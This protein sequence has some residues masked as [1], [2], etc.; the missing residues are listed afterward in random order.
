MS[1]TQYAVLPLC[2]ASMRPLCLC[3]RSQQVSSTVFLFAAATKT[4]LPHGS[5]RKEK[6]NCP[7]EAK[8]NS[9]PNPQQQR[10]SFGMRLSAA[11][12]NVLQYP[13]SPSQQLQ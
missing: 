13:P 6:E 11:A 3:G 2:G 7:A 8:R 5:I 12:Q 9:N 4:K 1:A 10:E